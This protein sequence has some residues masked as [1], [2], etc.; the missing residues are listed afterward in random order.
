MRSLN[1]NARDKRCYNQR[2][3]ERDNKSDRKRTTTRGIARVNASR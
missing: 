1:P 3:K 2:D